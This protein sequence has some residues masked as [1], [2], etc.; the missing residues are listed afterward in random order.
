MTTPFDTIGALFERSLFRLDGARS[1][2]ALFAVLAPLF[3]LLLAPTEWTSNEEN[4]FQL[5]YQKVAPEKFTPNH[6]VFDDSAARIVPY[7]LM[8]TT[9][10]WL[11]YESAHVALRISMALLYAF[12]LALFFSGLH[13]GAIEAL[14]IV[15]IFC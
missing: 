6:A 11:G 12:G 2:L 4:Y 3:L 5:A 1:G 9:I 15:A 8:G 14:L 13:A 7:M 10:K